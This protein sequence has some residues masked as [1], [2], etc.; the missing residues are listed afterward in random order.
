MQPK[1]PS[2]S[3]TVNIL[4]QGEQIQAS[5]IGASIKDIRELVAK[6]MSRRRPPFVIPPDFV[7]HVV[8]KSFEDPIFAAL[9]GPITSLTL[10]AQGDDGKPED[11]PVMIKQVPEDYVLR[12]GDYSV[13]FADANDTLVPFE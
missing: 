8:T 12:P 5:L 11:I 3:E 10:M 9:P 2:R 13:E 6:I 1:M 4:Y 7:P